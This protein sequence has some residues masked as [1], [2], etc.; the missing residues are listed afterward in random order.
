[1]K[2]QCLGIVVNVNNGRFPLT[3]GLL[4]VPN[5]EAPEGE[6]KINLKNFYEMFRYTKTHGLVPM[7]FLG[8]LGIFLGAGVKESKNA[9]TKLYKN[10]PYATL[11]V[12]I[13]L[14]LMQFLILLAD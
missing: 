11:V 4:R 2:Q 9:I 3:N 8:V 5:D 14:I 13:I 1:M 7:Q 6:E 12:P 10:L